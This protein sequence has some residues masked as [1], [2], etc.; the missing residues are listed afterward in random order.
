MKEIE[1]ETKIYPLMNAR[2][3]NK[4]T[5]T[6]TQQYVGTQRKEVTFWMQTPVT[7]KQKTRWGEDLR[8]MCY[9]TIIHAE[10]ET[11]DVTPGYSL[12]QIFYP[13]ANMVSRDNLGNELANSAI[14]L[15]W[16]GAMGLR[17][18]DAIAFLDDAVTVEADLVVDH[19]ALEQFDMSKPVGIMGRKGLISEIVSH[20][21]DSGKVEC[22][23]RVKVK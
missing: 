1:R 16:D 14:E 21:G 6:L 17:G 18:A 19:V 2:T 23:I 13:F 5:V 20:Y 7:G 22:E 12:P 11:G 8:V 15:R 10:Y 3:E 9:R 4:E